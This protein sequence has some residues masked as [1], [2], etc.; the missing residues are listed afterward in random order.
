MA[1]TLVKVLLELTL[2]GTANPEAPNPAGEAPSSPS[3]ELR[4]II[5]DGC[6][7][8]YTHECEAMGNMFVVHLVEV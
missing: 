7:A 6:G 8:T 3:Q 1:K 5:R 2:P 4:K